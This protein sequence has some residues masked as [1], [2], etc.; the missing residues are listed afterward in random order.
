MIFYNTCFK[1]PDDPRQISVL[2]GWGNTW[3][4][5]EWYIKGGV[6]LCS[7]VSYICT[8]TYRHT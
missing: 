3:G 2:G 1:I 7:H 8:C 5:G 4:S 6:G